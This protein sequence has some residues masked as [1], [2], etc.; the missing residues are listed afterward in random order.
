MAIHNTT[1]EQAFNDKVLASDKLVLVDFWAAWCPPCQAMAPVLQ[2]VA[3]QLEGSVDI[4]KV[5][6]EASADNQ[7]LAGDWQVQ[8]IPNMVV[9][10]DGAEVSR[11]I[12]MTQKPFLIDE[13]T[14]LAA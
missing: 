7:R 10:K 9:F 6:I 3:K 13:L 1:T 5:D 4:V 8:S 12:G 14:K 11:F 2:A